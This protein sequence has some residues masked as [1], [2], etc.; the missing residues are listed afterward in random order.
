MLVYRSVLPRFSLKP[1]F[2]LTPS[3]HARTEDRRP[4]CHSTSTNDQTQEQN[5]PQFGHQTLQVCKAYVR[6]NPPLNSLIRVQ[7]SLHF[8]YLK[9]LVMICFFVSTQLEIYV[10]VI[11][12]IL[13]NDW[14]HNLVMWPTFQRGYLLFIG[15]EILPMLYRDYFIS[16]QQ[17]ESKTRWETFQQ[18]PD[19]TRSMKSSLVHEMHGI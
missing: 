7:D 17:I 13:K 16:L 1:V 5:Q 19:M 11:W 15:H 8:R 12:I 4:G 6:E 14:H 2:F 9:L 3:H 18:K 10:Q